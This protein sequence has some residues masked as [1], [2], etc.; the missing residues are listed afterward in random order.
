MRGLRREGA[1]VLPEARFWPRAHKPRCRRKETIVF[2]SRLSFVPAL[3]VA[4]VVAGV[5]AGGAAARPP[6]D[7]PSASATP[8]GPQGAFVAARAFPL[9]PLDALAGCSS[10]A[11]TLSQPGDHVY[12]GQ[13]NGGYRACTP[14][15]TSVYDAPSN[16]FLPGNARRPDR[17][18]D[19]VPDR[20]QPRLR[21][22]LGARTRPRPG[23]DGPAV[24]VNGQPAS[25]TF[26]QPTYPGDP[27][28]PG[29]PGPAGAP[30]LAGHARRRTDTTRSRRPARRRS[31]GRRQ[32]P[33]RRAVPGQQA[34]DHA[35][36]TDARRRRLHGARSTTPAGPGVHLDGD[37]STEGWFRYTTTRP[38]TAA[39][40][41]TEPVGTEAWMP[42]NN[43]PSAKPTYD[44][45]DTVTAGRT[46]IANG[47]ACSRTVPTTRRTRT[48][49]AAR[50]RWHWQFA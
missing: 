22:H 40:V 30:G 36:A 3:V 24:T 27:N 38:A 1:P 26:V 7:D 28:G 17:P 14:T 45:Y 50:R 49:R 31:P 42:L 16:R 41:T 35:A 10:G 32:R 48:S 46:A 11:R 25:F 9:G 37:G 23:H 39:F 34:R 19:P 44:F 13:G 47:D 5:L 29:R 6:V 20:L 12:P 8:A 4:A 43:H 15:S 2:T 33:E 18:R 21:A